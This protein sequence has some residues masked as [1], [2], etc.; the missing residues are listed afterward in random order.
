M[1]AG[2]DGPDDRAV[3]IVQVAGEELLV[4]LISPPVGECRP[5]TSAGS[6]LRLIPRNAP[7]LAQVSGCMPASAPPALALP[8]LE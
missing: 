6:S 5:L 4:Q 8:A 3:A 1:R 2:V 7:N